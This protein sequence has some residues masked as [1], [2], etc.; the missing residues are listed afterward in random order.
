MVTPFDSFETNAYGIVAQ[1]MGYDAVWSP[2]SNVSTEHT[3]RVLFRSPS[4]AEEVAGIAYAPTNYIMEFY[5]GSFPGL[6]DA[7]NNG[8]EA[9]R[10][11]ING[12]EYY[13]RASRK[14][15]DGRTYC[16]T[17]EVGGL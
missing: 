2:Y 7:V 5:D 15:F 16:V 3:A 4:K 13:C 6:H 1:T 12:V 17:L 14:H 9:E 10:V 11:V 8:G